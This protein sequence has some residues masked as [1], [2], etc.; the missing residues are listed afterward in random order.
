[1]E[2]RAIFAGVSTTELERALGQLERRSF[3]PGAE[4]VAEGAELGE[5]FVVRKVRGYAHSS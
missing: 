3:P 5:M 2:T 4:V 1:M